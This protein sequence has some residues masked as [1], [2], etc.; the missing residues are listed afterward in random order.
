MTYKNIGL[1]DARQFRDSFRKTVVIDQWD[2]D[3]SM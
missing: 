1:N 2:M 3:L